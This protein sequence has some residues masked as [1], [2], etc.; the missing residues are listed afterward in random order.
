MTTIPWTKDAD[1]AFR[2]ARASG[3][4]VLLDFTA[5]PL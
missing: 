1:A 4:R 5:A 3:R 2:E